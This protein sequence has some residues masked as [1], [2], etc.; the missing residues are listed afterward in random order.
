[1]LTSSRLLANRRKLGWKSLAKIYRRGFCRTVKKTKIS[2][3]KLNSPYRSKYNEGKQG[4]ESDRK[5][6]SH[7]TKAVIAKKAIITN[8]ELS[9]QKYSSSKNYENLS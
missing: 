9:H 5:T 7:N 6:Y 2:L 4:V 1:M 8:L 3:S